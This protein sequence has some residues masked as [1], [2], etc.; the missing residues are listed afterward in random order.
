MAGGV[1]AA[2]SPRAAGM[3]DGPR[4]H[5][6]PTLSGLGSRH[7]TGASTVAPAWADRLGLTGIPGTR[8]LLREELLGRF[9]QEDAE[10]AVELAVSFSR[11]RKKRRKAPLG[12][13]PQTKVPVPVSRCSARQRGPPRASRAVKIS[14]SQSYHRL[15]QE[16]PGLRQAG[17]F[18][19]MGTQV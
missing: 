8:L 19:R 12:H 11:R 4:A 9:T 7:P 5:P 2:G 18:C 6:L 3:W 16:L 10:L 17:L 1:Q 14:T 13:E 15:M